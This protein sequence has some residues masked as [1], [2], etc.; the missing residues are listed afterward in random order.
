MYQE[1]NGGPSQTPT[2][3]S[4]HDNFRAVEKAIRR[5]FTEIASSQDSK[6]ARK[7]SKGPAATSGDRIFCLENIVDPRAPDHRLRRISSVHNAFALDDPAS[8]GLYII[9]RGLNAS[10]QLHW[11]KSALLTYSCSEHTNVSNLKRLRE[12]Q[13]R[14]SKPS[15]TSSDCPY[16]A[17]PTDS[18]QGLHEATPEESLWMKSI[19]DDDNF[20]AFREMRWC[21]DP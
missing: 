8:S 17:S 21:G 14:A 15:R 20:L 13:G 7:R 2:A 11:A 4:I 12:E 5:I 1:E 18:A 10:E 6:R 9:P 3:D 16:V 19:R